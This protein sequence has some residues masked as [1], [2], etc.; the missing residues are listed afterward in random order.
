M[1]KVKT[2]MCLLKQINITGAVAFS[3]THLAKQMIDRVNFNNTETIIELGAGSG[4]ITKEIAKKKRPEC[5]LLIF[6]VNEVFCDILRER[7]H[8]ENIFIINDSAEN[9]E[10]YLEKITGKPKVDCIISSLPFSILSKSVRESIF[11]S[12]LKILNPWSYYVQFGYNK[13][14]YK[15]LLNN[16]Q[17]VDTSFVIGNLPPAY[18]FNCRLHQDNSGHVQF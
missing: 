14:K 11:A 5:K 13:R 4:C 6:E 8:G 10:Y 17:T 9:M 3:S 2:W 18:V 15:Q 12:I 16:F 7:I 1:N